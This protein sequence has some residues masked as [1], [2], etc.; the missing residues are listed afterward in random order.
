MTE[1]IGKCFHCE[2]ENVHVTLKKVRTIS[3]TFMGQI[4]RV[5]QKE[6]LCEKCGDPKKI[7]KI[8]QKIKRDR[9]GRKR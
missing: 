7:I 8:R 9:G 3:T 4:V 6:D 5:P 1:R 2:E